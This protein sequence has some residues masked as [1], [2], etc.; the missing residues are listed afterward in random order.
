MEAGSGFRLGFAVEFV[1]ADLDILGQHGR[2]R[3]Q[4]VIA[5]A[6]LL[7]ALDFVAE[8]IEQQLPAAEAADRIRLTICSSASLSCSCLRR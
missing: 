8:V 4:A 2:R 1:V 5:A 3:I 6:A 7:E